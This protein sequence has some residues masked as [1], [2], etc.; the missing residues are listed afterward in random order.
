MS[1]EDNSFEAAAGTDLTSNLLDADDNG[2][3][4]EQDQEQSNI[5]FPI[6]K[7]SEVFDSC[8]AA[9]VADDNNMKVYLRV[10][11]SSAGKGTSTI[12]VENDT[13]IITSAPE[14]SKRAQYTKLE[15]R[16]YAFTRVFGP[17]ST[18]GDVFLCAAQPLFD[19]FVNGDSSVLF[20]YGMT[21]A[22]K[23]HTIQG[24][25]STPG[26]MPLLVQ[27]VLGHLH[28]SGSTE[29]DLNISMLEIYQEKIY[30]LLNEKKKKEKLSIRDG[31]GRVEVMG[32][33]QHPISSAE[34][35]KFYVSAV[36]CCTVLLNCSFLPMF[37]EIIFLF[38]FHTNTIPPPLLLL[39]CLLITH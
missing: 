19:R 7:L 33:S 12:E 27:E 37:I 32:L 14:S 10:R 18:Q 2:E 4:Q 30:D 9:K 39:L 21:N 11:P 6:K 25:K 22:G 20:A 17:D 29:W 16:Q 34:Q 38:F 26:I 8:V 1:F 28:M 24:N 3:E 13:S 15:R 5:K 36:L 23:T 35:G 31:N